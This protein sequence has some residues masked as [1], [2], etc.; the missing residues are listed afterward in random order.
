MDLGM[1][2]GKFLANFS[3]YLKEIAL[4]SKGQAYVL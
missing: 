4:F 3:I 2:E 1:G